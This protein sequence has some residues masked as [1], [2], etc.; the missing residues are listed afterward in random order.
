M[1]VERL[2]AFFDL[3]LPREGWKCLFTLPDRR[4][5]WFREHGRMAQMALRFDAE[6]KTVYCGTAAFKS[7]SRKA[8][9]VEA[10]SAL[11][12]DID[13]G[14]GKAYASAGVAYGALQQWLAACELPAPLVVGSGGGLHAYWPLDRAADLAEWGLGAGRLQALCAAHGLKVDT[15]IT[16]DTAR[17][18]R[19]PFTHN[20]KVGVA[21]VRLG[22]LVPA[23]SREQLSQLFVPRDENGLQYD[24]PPALLLSV[25]SGA[26]GRSV[27]A[28]ETAGLG[29]IRAAEPDPDPEAIAAGCAQVRRLR[30][31]GERLS[32]P[33]WYGVLGVLAH[34]GRAGGERAHSWS[35]H[36]SRY[37]LSDTNRKLDQA[38]SAAGP[39]TCQRFRD[40]NPAGCAGCVHADKITSPIQLGRP[41][42]ASIEAP[43]PPLLQLPVLPEPYFWKGSRLAVRNQTPSTKE[44]VPYHIITEYPFTVAELQEGE[45]TRGV[46]AICRT[47][48]PRWLDWRE[49]VIMLK[50]ALGDKGQATFAHHSVAVGKLRW[51][52]MHQFVTAMANHHKGTQDYGTRY[53]QFG[54]KEGAF[55]VGTDMVTSSATTRCY[56]GTEVERC[57][58]EMTAQ[59]SLAEWV[60]TVEQVT[61]RPGMEAHTF[62]A[63]C[64]FA[65]ILYHMSGAEGGT[66]VHATS[67][68]SGMG[69]TFAM[70]ISA[71]IWGSLA[72]LRLKERDTEVAKFVKIGTLCHLPVF[73]DELRST[74]MDAAERIKGFVLQYTLGEDKAR[75]APEGGLKDTALPWSNIMLSAANISLVDTCLSDGAETAQAARV[76]EFSPT[77]PAGVKVS[78]G[79]ALERAMDANRGNAGRAFAQHCLARWEWLQQAVPAAVRLWEQRLGGG[80]DLRYTLRL[81]GCVSVAMAL[82]QEMK[83]LRF[84]ATAATAWMES[85]ARE[86]A[87]RLA[88]ERQMDSAGILSRM[89]GDLLPHSLWAP[90]PMARGAAPFEQQICPRTPHGKLLMR[91]EIKG[92]KIL[93]GI[94]TIKTWMQEHKYPITEVGRELHQAGV[95]TDLRV[96]KTLGAG[97]QRT[98]QDWCWEIDGTHPD[99]AEIMSEGATVQE[100]NVVEF[101][102]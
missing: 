13:A 74:G 33:E 42:P 102:R 64:G 35:A 29:N 5:L 32:E 51:P 24:S 31:S 26:L 66:I 63:L 82:I 40:L 83:L 86:N 18:L 23:Y 4:H 30:D 70:K 17:I 84:D 16:C 79:D 81:L 96:R 54:F 76:F 52:H 2:T 50:D 21:P 7:K 55:V 57:A 69:K 20:R 93:I 10:L 97:W 92:A 22:P 58:K 41:L 78:D 25:Q 67:M 47:W 28:I 73:Y 98:G 99:I 53:E 6:G 1:S 15:T 95:V 9:N 38:R 72:A 60:K 88:V 75:G 14:E 101:K 37:A 34:C 65:S 91:Y 59:G 71:S 46:S 45:R 61:M 39:T 49:F 87:E 89:I 56:G 68:P 80:P 94:G 48:E 11:R 44:E 90:G 77:L 8:D 19:P 100:S 62:V 3:I 36:D 27:P 85:V 43:S 12:L